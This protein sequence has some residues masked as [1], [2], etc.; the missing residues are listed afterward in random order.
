MFYNY[1][2]IIATFV[3]RRVQRYNDRDRCCVVHPRSDP[4]RC[5]R[6][7]LCVLLQGPQEGTVYR[8]SPRPSVSHLYAVL[9]ILGI[10][11]ADKPYDVS[12]VL[13]ATNEAHAILCTSSQKIGVIDVDA[14]AFF[15][16]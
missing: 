16:M 13:S 1:K 4:H 6:M 2:H 14:P 15:L 7:C 12:A 5:G 11:A 8:H 10:L 3:F 9:R